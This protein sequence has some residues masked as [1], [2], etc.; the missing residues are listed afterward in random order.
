M[1]ASIM[2]RSV[3]AGAAIALAAWLSLGIALAEPAAQAVP[4]RAPDSYIVSGSGFTAGATIW[5]FDQSAC[6]GARRCP[7]DWVVGEGA[8][9]ASGHFSV[10]VQLDSS[11]QP[12]VGQ[13]QR[14]LAVIQADW[15]PDQIAAGPFIQVPLRHSG[16][17]GA[18]NVGDSQPGADTDSP[19]GAETGL[20][21]ALVAAAG[22]FALAA[23]RRHTRA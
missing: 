10:T 18:P 4:G 13:T 21:L 6:G 17:P 5:V 22:L 15:T 7:G 2:S 20:G 16:S 12:N 1:K 8:V 11:W 19:A 23:R 9:D 3:A 14:A